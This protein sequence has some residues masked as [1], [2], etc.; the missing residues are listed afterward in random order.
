[1]IKSNLLS[2]NKISKLESSYSDLIHLTIYQ[3]Y[4]KFL[5]KIFDKK[6]GYWQSGDYNYHRIKFEDI[7]EAKKVL[8]NE[9]F[10]RPGIYIW[11]IEK[12]NENIPLYIGKTTTSFTKR[13]NRYVNIKNG[14]FDLAIKY[15]EIA[16]EQPLEIKGIQN[17]YNISRVRA[18]GVKKFGESKFKNIW[19]ILIPISNKDLISGIEGSLIDVGGSW[20]ITKGYNPLINLA[21]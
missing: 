12:R 9:V 18:V 1:M 6:M 5:K 20:N 16:K 3:E 2:V 15:S 14:Q 19:V 11:G 17:K 4:N 10:H 13:F 7:K 8:R 21:K